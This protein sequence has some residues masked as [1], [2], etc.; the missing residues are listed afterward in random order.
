MSTE[1]TVTSAFVEELEGIAVSALGFDDSE[2][3]IKS[4]AVEYERP[5]KRSEYLMA[6]VGGSRVIR[7]WAVDVDILEERFVATNTLMGRK[8]QIRII[9]Y[10]DL[11]NNG[12]GVA[13][14]REHKRKVLSEIK[15]LG[16]SVSYS[17]SVVLDMIDEFIETSPI[18]VVENGIGGDEGFMLQT[19]IV[20][21]GDKE[22]ITY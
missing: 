12:S 7:C 8:Y 15:D 14:L 1:V 4:Y 9:G 13:E 16:P 18:E 17:G 22:G 10:Y 20:L 3:N 2:G 19:E 6:D 11:G 21:V 5:T